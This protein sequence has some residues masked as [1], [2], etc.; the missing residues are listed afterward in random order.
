MKVTRET[1]RLVAP[2]LL[3][4]GMVAVLTHP[5]DA[6]PAPSAPDAYVAVVDR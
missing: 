1:A 3:A 2:P 6:V 5:A 4:L